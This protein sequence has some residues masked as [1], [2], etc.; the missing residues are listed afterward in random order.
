M[1][2]TLL[3]SDHE[4][5]SVAL[6]GVSLVERLCFDPSAIA[7][8]RDEAQHL[9]IGIH[10]DDADMV[11]FQ[12]AMRR[13]GFDP[14]GVGIVDLSLL[15]DPQALDA[16]LAGV[17][18]RTEAFPG[19]SPEQAKLVP[20]PGISRRSLLSALV[21]LT[22]GAPLIDRG[23]C[24]ADE[25]CRA[26][27]TSCPVGALTWEGG[28]ISYDKAACVA[29]GICVTTCP[30]G[31][32]INPTVTPEAVEAQIAAMLDA[33]A[34]APVGIRYMCRDGESPGGPGWLDVYVPCTGMLTASWLL[35]PLA[36]GAAATDATPCAESGCSLGN[37]HRIASTLT[38]TR[39]ILDALGLDWERVGP[40][41]VTL[42]TPFPA[43]TANG[44][45]F[46]PS[47]ERQ[48]IECL[49]S[50]HNTYT[51]AASLDS[52]PVGA[53]SIDPVTCTAC[54]ICARTC[55]TN[56]LTATTTSE[57]VIEFD[58]RLC[59]ACA[60]CVGACPEIERSAISMST[61]FDLA[62]WE[63]GRREMRRDSVPK[64]ES[65]GK[66]VAPS[67]ML[68]RITAMLGSEHAATATIL[69][70]RCLDCRGR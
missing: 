25:G 43:P 61:G 15:T 39:T 48:V 6:D 53:V 20:A 38:D 5:P 66:P 59:V 69:R 36:M 40:V 62:D 55:P 65:C 37:D 52:T 14:L 31:A 17:V 24:V 70:T 3:C 54:A 19:A 57:V 46:G 10:R 68:E 45:M 1:T 7:A 63:R 9:V 4:T 8:V 21:P 11:R 35:A 26:C 51:A 30:V 34:A 13:I 18:A 44:P 67:A 22:I 64:C 29:C 16:T 42:L 32:V 2:Q 49:A 33:S 23:A 41:K 27:A 60:Q 50:I 28:S 47:A 56:A 12:S 58:P